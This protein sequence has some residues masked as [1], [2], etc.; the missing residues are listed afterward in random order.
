LL[1]RK[2]ET[3][4]RKIIA[5]TVDKTVT[6]RT[7]RFRIPAMDCAMEEKEIRAV[8]SQMAEV[9][10]MKFRLSDRLLDVRHVGDQTAIRDMIE[11]AGFKTESAE[12]KSPRE[13]A[14]RMA[15]AIAVATTLVLVGHF[16]LPYG[17]AEFILHI[18][19]IVVAGLPMMRKAIVALKRFR[20]DMNVLITVAIFGA[21]AIGE[22]D[23]A[24]VVTI[25]FAVAE[26]LEALSLDRA[27]SAIGKL[28]AIAP[29]TARV[30]RGGKEEIVPAEEIQIG[31]TVILLPGEIS[32]VD[33]VVESGRSHVVQAAITGESMPVEKEEGDTVFAGT[34]NGESAVQIKT[35]HSVEDTTLARIIEMVETAE[36]RRAP[37]Q[38][39]VDSFARWYTPLVM[40]MAAATAIILPQVNVPAEEAVYRALALLVIA[41]PCA[42]VISTPVSIVS[43]LAAATRSGVLIKG[44]A[45]LE[46][47][48]KAD[49]V[50]FDKTGTLT[51][52][53]PRLTDVVASGGT[54]AREIIEAAAALESRSEHPLAK[55][56]LDH[57][58]ENGIAFNPATG[59]QALRGYGIVGQIGTNLWKITKQ[60]AEERETDCPAEIHEKARA[61]ASEGKTVATILRGDD[62]V[63]ILAFADEIRP[64]AAGAIR[65]IRELGISEFR[66]LTG[67]NARTA[68]TIGRLAGIEKF[69]AECLPDEKIAQVDRAVKSGKSVIFVGDGVNDAP[70]LAAATVGVAMGAAG[71]DIA[72]E[73]ADVALMGDDLTS[74]PRAI[75][76]SRRTRRIIAFNI[77]LSIGI[78]VIFVVLALFGHAR[79]WGAIAADMGASL[80]V[81]ANGLRLL[82]HSRD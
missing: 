78:K 15:T 73:T 68:E 24:A 3:R 23:E 10:G 60:S 64:E 7:S 65:K 57:A 69:D 48:G 61:L 75:A 41:C 74:L 20:A 54:T 49:V 32:P 35:T 11:N 55:A 38:R 67:D 62:P 13:T 37:T 25:L 6:I 53:K 8:L 19:A 12:E 5:M 56:V 36:L 29:Q 18:A 77:A 44:G 76:L 52:G 45:Y 27:R 70:A 33:G 46:A 21:I 34:I 43:A 79:L 28:L 66:M 50:F 14:R 22:W 51:H 31:E 40:V 4:G 2:R 63:G 82:A 9:R 58:R 80:L 47:L 81:I 26:F 30:M 16:V 42:L 72:L 39:F 59:V 1:P 17:R 71:S